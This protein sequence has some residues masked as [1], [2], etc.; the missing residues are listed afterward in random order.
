MSQLQARSFPRFLADDPEHWR[1]R[2]E[3]LRF[4]AQD[5]TDAKS[6]AIMLRIADDYSK[7][8]LRAELRTKGGHEVRA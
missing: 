4:I 6:K 5:I 1:L 3:Q 8:A 2:G 7:L